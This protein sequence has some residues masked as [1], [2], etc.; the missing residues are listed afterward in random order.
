LRV[1]A[2]QGT[3]YV[4]DLRG[5][6]PTGFRGLPVLGT[7]PCAEGCV[8]CREVCPTHAISLA[9]LRLDLGRCVFCGL[10]EEACPE[11]KIE[12]TT[13][14][15]LAADTPGRLVVSEGAADVVRVQAAEAFAKLFGR[16][17]KLRQVSAGGCNACE[18]ELN[19]LANVNFDLQRY[20][21][22]WV[23]SPRHADAL[24]LSGPLTRTMRDAVQLSW[25]AMPEP[26][27]LV[28]TGACA[29]SGGLYEGAAGVD[30]TFLTS[31]GPALYVPGCPPHPLTFVH[32]ILDFL[33][34]A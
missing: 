19:A 13:S 16:S 3:Q 32:A 25:E 33:G 24:V 23:A 14:P 34:V 1:R 21:I 10:C 12:F 18:L 2:S 31:V 27:F 7:A 15:R 26:R 22:E 8:A 20:G 4:A 11:D 5:A 28:A 6:L 9:P 17:L 29:I 30:R